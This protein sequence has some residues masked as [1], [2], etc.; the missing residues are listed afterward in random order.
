V[1]VRG[2]GVDVADIDR[3]AA[4]LRRTPALASRL[5]TDAEQRTA[6]GRP[7]TAASLAARF[8]AKEAVAKVLEHAE[9]GWRLT[10][11]GISSAS[12]GRPALQVRGPLARRA[13]ELGIA[14]WHVSLSHDRGT[15]VAVVIGEG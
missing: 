1:S 6:A 5:F 3:L 8:A 7:R 10:D 13:N 15:A 4:A 2:V 14:T 12:S 11:V 9:A